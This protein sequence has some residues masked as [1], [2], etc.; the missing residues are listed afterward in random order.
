MIRTACTT[1]ANR[2]VWPRTLSSMRLFALAFAL[3]A[4]QSGRPAA[5][6]DLKMLSVD[7][8][9][10]RLGQPGVH[11]FDANP[12]ER[13]DRGHVPGAVWVASD[14]VTADVLPPDKDATLIFYCANPH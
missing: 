1:P 10:A 14:R 8:V 9:A 5:P 7:E 4:C 6:Q 3:V 11:V 13:Y 2:F 12:R